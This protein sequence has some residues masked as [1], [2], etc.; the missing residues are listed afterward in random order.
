MPRNPR[1]CS[2]HCRCPTARE[3]EERDTRVPTSPAAF[4]ITC[5]PAATRTGKRIKLPV[6]ARLNFF[7]RTSFFVK[8]QKG[9]CGSVVRVLA[10]LCLSIVKAWARR[11]YFP[12]LAATPRRSK[13]RPSHHR[14]GVPRRCQYQPSTASEHYNVQYKQIIRPPPYNCMHNGSCG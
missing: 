5:S 4:F 9:L 12:E 11:R 3:D 8:R 6:S 13:Q 1:V 2:V 14:E 10:C 7:L